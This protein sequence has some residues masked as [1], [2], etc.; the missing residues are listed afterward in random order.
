M[1][2]RPPPDGPDHPGHAWPPGGAG[3]GATAGTVLRRNRLRTGFSTGANAAAAATAATLG[4]VTGQVPDWVE[5][6]LPNGQRARFAIVAGR[7]MGTPPDPV[8]EPPQEP[9]RERNWQR[10]RAVSVKDAGDDP[11]VTHG[12]HLT[13]TVARLPGAV[14]RV[15][16]RGGDGV[17]VV[18][19]PGLGLTVG[20]AAINPVPRRNILTN[21]RAAGAPLLARDGLAVCISVPG[22]AALAQ[23]T[24]NPRL[25]ILGG[26]SILGTTGIVHPYSSAAFRAAL[27]QAVRVAHRQ[28]QTRLVFSTG[29]RTEQAAM[30]ARP[31][32]PPVCFVQMGDFV[33]A[34]LSTAIRLGCQEISVAAMIGK[35][36]KMAQG[37]AITHAHRAPLDRDLVAAAAAEVGAPPALVASIRTAATARFAAEALADLG[38]A[39]ALHQAMARRAIASLRRAYPGAYR[40]RILA[41]DPAGALLVQVDDPAEPP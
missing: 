27:V 39:E 37:L 3:T 23:R 7:L 6:T 41:C 24:L 22:G 12:A 28:G 34:A 25:G 10:A 40:L 19:R 15:D 4:L 9:G 30:A 32:L 20:D 29:G 17:G 31:D 36:T 11:D 2:R 38:L 35:L 18:T 8:R 14:G 21:V 33:K 26:I 13:A 16:L 1:P 5:V